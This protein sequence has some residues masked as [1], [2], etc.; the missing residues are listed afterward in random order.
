MYQTLEI[1][2]R[3]TFKIVF[4]KILSP[5]NIPIDNLVKINHTYFFMKLIASGMYLPRNTHLQIRA[6]K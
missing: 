3:K 5:F 6:Y 4:S 2:K 1:C